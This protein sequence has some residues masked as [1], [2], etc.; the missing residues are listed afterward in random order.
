MKKIFSISLIIIGLGMCLFSVYPIL[1]MNKEVVNSL[2]E[3][4]DVK[5][6]YVLQNDEIERKVITDD[7]I[8]T[9]TL[10]GFNDKIPIR[11]GT[12]ENVLKKGIGLDEDTTEI[13]QSGNSVLYGHREK[14]L[15]NLKNVKIDD[16]IIIETLT[17]NFIFRINDIKIVD[18]DDPFIYES[19]DESTITLVTC[20]PFIYMGPTPQRYVVKATLVNHGD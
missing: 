20:Y 10:V 17:D 7:L 16:D 14:I 8:G 3:W 1:E 2:D 18:P 19:A 11:M 12:T 6:Y 15:W 4:E 13:G 5:Q 9:L